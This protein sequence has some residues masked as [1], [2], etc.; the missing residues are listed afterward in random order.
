MISESKYKIFGKNVLGNIG[1]S[2]EK[3]MINEYGKEKLFKNIWSLQDFVLKNPTDKLI[4]TSVPD[5]YS[6][7]ETLVEYLP[8]TIDYNNEKDNFHKNLDPVVIL[9]NICKGARVEMADFILW[10]KQ[11]HPYLKVATFSRIDPV[12]HFE[13][14]NGMNCLG[15]LFRKSLYTYND[16]LFSNIF[17]DL[18]VSEKNKVKVT[19]VTGTKE[20]YNGETIAMFILKI[21]QK[22]KEK[23]N[24]F[25]FLYPIED[26]KEWLY[27]DGDIGNHIVVA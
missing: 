12:L 22:R 27:N 8:R 20:E 17:T 14:E 13:T 9:E 3:E 26:H 19:M 18:H 7:D 25:S 10:N 2:L 21:L 11:K 24:G 5:A 6:I 4:M 1:F 23:I 16:M 15:T